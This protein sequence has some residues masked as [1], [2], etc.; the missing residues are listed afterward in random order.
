[1]LDIHH[2]A[3]GRGNST[4]LICPDGT[5]ILID[6]GDNAD[7]TD[8]S[9]E[10]KPNA[11]VRPG[12]W[13][14][15][16]ALRA[17]RAA[18]HS[19]IDYFV[20]S[21]LHPDHVDAL[22][23]V[24]ARVRIGKVIDRGFPDYA[25]PAPQ[26]QAQFASNYLAFVRARNERREPCERIRTGRADQIIPLHGPTSAFSIRN[27]A[28]NGEVWTGRGDNTRQLFPALGSLRP[29]DYPTENMCSLALRIGYGKFAYFTGGDLTC[30]YEES[31]LA[32]RDVET[33]VAEACGPVSVAVANHHGYFDAVGAGFVKALRPRVFVIPAWY[34]AHPDIQPLRRMLSERLY[35][36]P[37]DVFATS[38]MAANRAVNNQFASK[39]KSV[40]GHVVVR[41][42][43]GGGDFRVEVVDNSDDSGRI[44]G[45][46]GPYRLV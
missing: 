25:Y 7:S 5:T 12:E 16:Y 30:D 22:Y 9:A 11:R 36:G 14:A 46:F 42:A 2:L 28:A 20:L 43:P 44:T 32:W 39:L 10:Q 38:L 21:H 6:A 41:V 23:D 3:Y 31:G 26:Q 19:E 35:P 18:G 40:E 33:P 4:F 37:R 13:I 1:M 17:M 27:L 34:V 45:S 24:A 15:S 8:V 29:E